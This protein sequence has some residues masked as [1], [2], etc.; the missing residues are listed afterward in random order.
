MSIG[1]GSQSFESGL[2]ARGLG[3]EVGTTSWFGVCGLCNQS[4]WF[5][6]Y[7]KSLC[8]TVSVVV[9]VSIASVVMAEQAWSRATC[10][11]L[12]QEP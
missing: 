3:S 9:F 2:V 7:C 12:K 8:I 4:Y 6:C 1:Y 10:N 11:A 5:G